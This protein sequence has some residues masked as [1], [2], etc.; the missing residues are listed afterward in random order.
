MSNS[1]SISPADNKFAKTLRWI[2]WALIATSVGLPQVFNATKN[3]GAD[4]AIDAF[5]RSL[6]QLALPAVIAWWVTRKSA[7]QKKHQA[8]FVVGL[9]MLFTTLV[10]SFNE[11]RSNT[12]MR[13]YV[14]TALILNAEGE[15]KLQALSAK[16][17]AVNLADALM[18]ENFT[19]PGRRAS[20]KA[21]VAQY[22][23]LVFERKA[24]IAAQLAKGRQL[25]DT[26]PDGAVRDRAEGNFKRSE[27]EIKGIYDPLETTQL[28]YV[29]AVETLLLWADTQRIQLSTDG[30]P[31]FETQEA[32]DQFRALLGRLLERQAA[33]SAAVQVALA[34]QAVVNQDIAN[35]KTEAERFV[36]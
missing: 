16:L 2:G 24:L 18:M 23:S 17:D 19:H 35:I 14:K 31:L 20:A 25:L 5:A 7:P 27:A 28:A 1:I 13:E 26:L 34:K 22:R 6:G 3:G 10:V 8:V 11:S 9:V 32:L 36:K 12:A 30:Q 33:F 29:D 21:S 4:L 15:A